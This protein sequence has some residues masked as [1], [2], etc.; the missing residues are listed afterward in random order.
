MKSPIVIKLNGTEITGRLD[1]IESFNITLRENDDDGGL[2]KSYSTELRFFDDGY[3]IL[4]SA[5]IDDPNGFA[6]QVDVQ[7]FDECCG[8]LVFDGFIQGDGIDW[9]EPECWVS[10]QVVEKKTA[11][12]CIKSKLIYDNEN[13]FLNVQQKKL[14]YCVDIRPDFIIG[15]LI[16]LS[17][18]HI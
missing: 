15:I 8:R 17:L 1:G 14:R 9:C 10:A 7:I 11:L 18:I 4:K 5:L 3:S 12:N 6:N 2:A 13:G 16:F